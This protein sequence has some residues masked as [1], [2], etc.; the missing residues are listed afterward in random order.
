MKTLH[1]IIVGLLAV[2]SVSFAQNK[3]PA[4]MDHSKMQGM[5]HSK[6]AV[7]PA[8]LNIAPAAKDAVATV[9]RFSKALS[10]GQLNKAGAELDAGVAALRTARPDHRGRALPREG[11]SRGWRVRPARTP[12]DR[13]RSSAEPAGRCRRSRR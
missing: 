7:K 11:R 10:S 8:T 13:A 1:L 6:M 9:D 5:D 2:S 12:A 4:P 3:T